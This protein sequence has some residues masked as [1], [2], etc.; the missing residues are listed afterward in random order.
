M[1]TRDS[2]SDTAVDADTF[3]QWVRH[4]AESRDMTEHE[5]L[6]Q[7]VSAFWALDE[8]GDIALDS[9]SDPGTTL[10]ETGR[11]WNPPRGRPTEDE[12]PSET[13][14]AGGDGT[15]A[16]NSS[17]SEPRDQPNPD[18]LDLR[19]DLTPTEVELTKRIA[20]MRRQVID[21]SLDVEQ[22]RSRQE[23]FTDR[24]SDDV[25]RLHSEI[26]SLESRVDQDNGDVVDRIDT[27][28]AKLDDVEGAQAEL[29]TWIDEEF[30]QIEALFE[31]ILDT[32]RKFDDRIEE[33]SAT[34]DTVSNAEQD[35]E[36][37]NTLR[38]RA[39][40]KGIDTGR[41]EDCDTIVDL[42]MLSEPSCP[43]CDEQFRDI[44]EATSWNP[45]SKPTLLTGGR[46]SRPPE[47]Q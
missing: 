27:V 16:P 45:F 15:S 39:I 24:L 10:S 5:L 3:Q 42:S 23:E 47:R 20:E 41:C 4:T 30:D 2:E 12:V 38:K 21:L 6:N 37:L 22:Q 32:V 34:V 44:E 7:L 13:E 11:D 17:N 43:S 18:D 25:T 9:T 28:E 1:G 14:T 26:Q 36:A 29:E 31:Q 40:R 8:M 35:R 46:L 19:D 33:L